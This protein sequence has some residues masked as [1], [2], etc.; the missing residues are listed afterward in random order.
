M[1]L[2]FFRK[3]F[4]LFNHM[5]YSTEKE[6]L[7]DGFVDL[8]EK[9]KQPEVVDIAVTESEDGGYHYPS[10]Y[11]DNVKGL[12]KLPKEGTA[13][14][15]YK[16]VSERSE[17]TERDGKTEK[18]HSVELCIYGIKPEGESFESEEEEDDDDAIERGLEEA[19]R[20]NEE[21]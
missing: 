4:H 21:D 17:K 14:I 13:V 5:P 11:F 12:E 2:S 9:M 18:R 8:S 1:E 7:P 20:E 3:K 10:L 16:K 19:M 6:S 15:K